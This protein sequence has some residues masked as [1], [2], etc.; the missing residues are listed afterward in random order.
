M[1]PEEEMPKGLPRR[2]GLKTVERSDHELQ[3]LGNDFGRIPSWQTAQKSKRNGPHL[4]A[5]T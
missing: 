2:S 5:S 4:G 1:P 3:G